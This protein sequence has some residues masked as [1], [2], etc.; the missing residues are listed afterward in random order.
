MTK[1][2][3]KKTEAYKKEVELKFPTEDEPTKLFI[4]KGVRIEQCYSEHVNY[5]NCYLTKYHIPANKIASGGSIAGM[6]KGL[7]YKVWLY[8]CHNKANNSVL[9][10]W[11]RNKLPKGT[12]FE[13]MDDNKKV[14]IGK[15]IHQKRM[16]MIEE[17]FDDNW[18]PRS[19]IC[20]LLFGPLAD[21]SDKIT[22]L[23]INDESASFIDRQSKGKIILYLLYI[24]IKM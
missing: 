20:W 13:Q 15:E 21:E 8:Y 23:R 1:V 19:W 10:Y 22:S 18:Y 9:Q 17:G 6:L 5:M 14:I 11:R 24:T 4:W 7:R 12:K 16:K 2:F 3:L